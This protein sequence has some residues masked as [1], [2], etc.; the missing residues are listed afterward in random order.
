M[1][2]QNSSLLNI[3]PLYFTWQN[4]NII[5]QSYILFS[6]G[7]PSA[8]WKYFVRQRWQSEQRF[9]AGR[10]ERRQLWGSR[11]TDKR[12]A[13]VCVV[14]TCT[15][16]CVWEWISVG[17]NPTRTVYWI[18][19]RNGVSWPAD[20]IRWG[21]RPESRYSPVHQCVC[22]CVKVCWQVNGRASLVT[23]CCSVSIAIPNC[24]EGTS[25]GKTPNVWACVCV[26]HF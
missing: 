19:N 18:R 9:Q 23:S 17:F 5:L 21:Q 12:A 16:V 10:K 25:R 13:E 24:I 2:P 8:V 20:R 22:A 1:I 15:G 6:A 26:W 7:A 3:F 4:I 11:Q 14:C